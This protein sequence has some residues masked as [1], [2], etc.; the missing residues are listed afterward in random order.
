[1]LST[2]QGLKEL[3]LLEIENGF[4]TGQVSY[5]TRNH[6]NACVRTGTNG[7]VAM[8]FLPVTSLKFFINGVDNVFRK[9]N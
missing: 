1:M 9:A 8:R 7:S 6:P 4:W 5:V 3:F 2:S